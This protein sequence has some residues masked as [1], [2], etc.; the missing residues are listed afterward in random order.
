MIA[1]KVYLPGRWNGPLVDAWVKEHRGP[2]A[3]TVRKDN[4]FKLTST[5]INLFYVRLMS[6]GSAS[7]KAKQFTLLALSV[8]T[9]LWGTADDSWG[10]NE[11]S[12]L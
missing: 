8:L 5:Y 12:Y 10:E 11:N 6:F 7:T 2:V 3:P 9:H 1:G 4:W